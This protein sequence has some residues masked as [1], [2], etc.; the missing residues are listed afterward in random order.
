MLLGTE[1]AS[2]ARSGRL[3]APSI[4]GLQFVSPLNQGVFG[5]VSLD[6]HPEAVFPELNSLLPGHNRVHVIYVPGRD[7]WIIERLRRSGADYKYD[8]LP[9]PA[10]SL[11]NATDHVSAAL[12]YGN[13]ATDIIWLLGGSNLVT[14]DTSAH[15]FQQAYNAKF[16]VFANRPAWV[17][18][19]AFLS[20]EPDF[21]E[22]GAQMSN[23]ME[24]VLT[25][26]ERHF[27]LTA[28]IKFAMNVRVA[29]RVG[30]E[31]T[32]EVRDRMGVLVADD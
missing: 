23:L 17:E 22:Y 10:A 31:V 13:P 29:R 16:P 24:R 28:K 9:A 26:R 6:F 1:A 7:E 30:I 15:L 27:Q 14:R 8:V 32:Q 18:E 5:G 12:R 2:L 20:G 19:G 25:S 4:A 3:V 21:I 11:R